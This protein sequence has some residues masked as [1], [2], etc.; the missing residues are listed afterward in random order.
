MIISILAN[1]VCLSL[2]DY[3]DPDNKLTRN[4]L[5][6]IF[7]MVFT[8]IYTFE[9]SMKTL[10]FGFVVHQ[11]SYLRDPWNAL[12]FFSLVFSYINMLPGVPNFK[13]IR[14]FRVIKP[15]R[16]INS[17]PTMKKLFNTLLMS[18]PHIG[19]VVLFLI[20]IYGI[21]ATIGNQ[22][23]KGDLYHRCRLTQKPLNAIPGKMI[24]NWPADPN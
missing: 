10:A 2:Y 12:D 20:F 18:I 22:L 16:S 15:L 3:S 13:A 11:K 24:M 1:S 7:D 6:G 14:I 21:F 5:L 4:H 19:Q 17:M 8:G 23:F 9:A